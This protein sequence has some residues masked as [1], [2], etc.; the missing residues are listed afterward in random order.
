MELQR[1][2]GNLDST[3][4]T[5]RLGKSDPSYRVMSIGEGSYQKSED[6]KYQDPFRQIP[7]DSAKFISS[8]SQSHYFQSPEQQG[9]PINFNSNNNYDHRHRYTCHP[10]SVGNFSVSENDSAVQLSVG[11]SNPN[12]LND[13]DFQLMNIDQNMSPSSGITS[14]RFFQI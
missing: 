4:P 8:S 1:P 10:N 3:F 2:F 9:I 5:P 11:H 7:V 13:T 12:L 14:V 6:I